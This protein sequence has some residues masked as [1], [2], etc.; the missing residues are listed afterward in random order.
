[1]LAKNCLR[2]WITVSTENMSCK[3][4]C[5]NEQPSW[6][7]METAKYNEVKSVFVEWFRHKWV[8]SLLVVLVKILPCVQ[9]C[10]TIT[11]EGNVV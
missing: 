7:R 9:E 2:S 5:A 11:K 8:V 10:V 4:R 1:M 3:S 6:K